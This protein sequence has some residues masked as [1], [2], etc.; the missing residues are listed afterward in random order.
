MKF[1]FVLPQ[2]PPFAQAGVNEAGEVLFDDLTWYCDADWPALPRDRDTVLVG[3]YYHQVERVMWRLESG[4]CRVHLSPGWH[5]DLG[6][7]PGPWYQ[8]CRERK[9]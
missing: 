7:P 1:T 6:T 8:Y 2:D 5:N 3:R 4:E 9:G